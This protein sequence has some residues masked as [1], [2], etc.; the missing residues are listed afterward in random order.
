MGVF[1]RGNVH[2]DVIVDRRAYAP[3]SKILLKADTVL[4]DDPVKTITETSVNHL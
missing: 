2:M 1:S 4:C 3:G